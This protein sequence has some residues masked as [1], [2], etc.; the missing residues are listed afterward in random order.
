V[1]NEGRTEPFELL[2]VKVTNV[3]R[4]GLL[5][6]AVEWAGQ[7]RKVTI[8]YVNADCLNIAAKDEAYRRLLNQFDL[9]YSDGVGVVWAG[10]FLEQRKLYK[11][12]GRA[13][14]EEFCGMCQEQGISLF[15]LGG[16]SG[17][18]REAQ[19][20]LQGR[21][22]KLQILGVCDGYFREMSEAEVLGE[23]EVKKPDVLLVGMGVPRQEKW[24]Q[25]NRKKIPAK[26]CWAVGALFDYVAGI[27]LPVPG[28]MERLALEWMW[29]MMVDPQGKLERYMIGTPLFIGRVLW[30]KFK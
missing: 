12:T 4:E 3:N 27:E 15:L 24:I 10:R 22:P 14:I 9:V 28:W 7:T 17:I 2:G 19:R 23:I 25:A 29:R 13:W 16:K 20:R 21:L 11:V 26:L 30:Q 5:K 18:A 6:Q 1:K 8:S